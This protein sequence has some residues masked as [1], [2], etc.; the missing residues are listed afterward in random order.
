MQESYRLTVKTIPGIEGFGRQ[1]R[2]YLGEEA[3]PSRFFSTRERSIS[4]KSKIMYSVLKWADWGVRI[5]RRYMM[6]GWRQEPS[7][8]VHPGK[9]QLGF[10]QQEKK[11][12]T[13]LTP[14]PG[15]GGAG[16]P[17]ISWHFE[18]MFGK[19]SRHIFTN[20]AGRRTE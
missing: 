13:N 19:S 4:M 16:K 18:P 6:F 10:H 12:T 17:K 20:M 3:W 8:A 2:H 9:S 1:N 5:S 14:S 15:G 11:N 7:R